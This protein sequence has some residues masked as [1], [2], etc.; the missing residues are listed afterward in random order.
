MPERS[1][2]GTGR[3][4]DDVLELPLL[5]AVIGLL[6]I[7]V[8]AGLG[9]LVIGRRLGYNDRLRDELKSMVEDMQRRTDEYRAA[10]KM[11]PVIATFAY[12]RSPS[13][14]TFQSGNARAFA[15]SAADFASRSL[16][17]AD[18]RVG[19]R[20]RRDRV[21][22]P[23][24]A[25]LGHLLRC[26][27]IWSAPRRRPRT[28]VAPLDGRGSLPSPRHA[29]WALPGTWPLNVVRR[30]GPTAVCNWRFGRRTT[31]TP[32]RPCGRPPQRRLGSSR[33]ARRRSSHRARRRRMR[34]TPRRSPDR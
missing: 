19:R 14:A 16:R 6:L 23:Y 27:R 2:R 20:I 18:D 9:G 17:V 26:G 34:P 1:R 30:S 10:R 29:G 4:P 8:A 24:S 22:G 31:R 25:V 33:P 5:P 32:P 11:P 15:C 7:A 21:N 3:Y 28:S 13:E 12:K